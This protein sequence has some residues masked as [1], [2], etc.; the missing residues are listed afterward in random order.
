[1][2]WLSLKLWLTD[3]LTDLLLGDAIAGALIKCTWQGIT[4]MYLEQQQRH[5]HHHAPRPQKPLTPSSS[6]S[7][8]NLNSSNVIMIT[9]TATR[10]TYGGMVVRLWRQ[11]AS[12][13]CPWLYLP[14]AFSAIIFVFINQRNTCQR[15]GEIHFQN[16]RNTV[17]IVL[18][19]I[20]SFYPWL[21]STNHLS[22]NQ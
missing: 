18:I 5:H 21:S 20:K 11:L 3:L 19:L 8:I 7:S 12:Q 9:I 13:S 4:K 6:S 1:M 14:T 10:K 16:L 15:F 17:C 22:I 2:W